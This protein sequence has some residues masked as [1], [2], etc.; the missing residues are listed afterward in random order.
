MTF[1]RLTESDLDLLH[2]WLNAPHV[3]EW[4]DRPGPTLDEVREKYLPRVTGPSDVVPYI[5][6]RDEMPIGYIQLYPVQSGAWGLAD[7]HGG[8]GLDLFIGDVR[9][10][11]GGLGPRILRQF[12]KEIAFRDES[13]DE[14]F[15]DPSPRNRIA[16]RVFEKAGFRYVAAAIDPDTGVE[17]RLMR[18]TRSDF[19]KRSPSAED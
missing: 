6:C 9:C 16:I 3:L 10:L 11:H 5:I 7:V 17:V 14:C 8:A 15:I 1:R 19:E 13:T 4:W 12:L 2:R 18:I